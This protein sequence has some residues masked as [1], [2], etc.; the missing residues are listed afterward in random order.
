MVNELC[1]IY[2]GR[3]SEH[4]DSV[5]SFDNLYRVIRDNHLTL[6]YQL[7]HVIYIGLDNSVYL[8]A[9]DFENESIAYRVI[10][11]KVDLFDTL[12]ELHKRRCFLFSTL[13]SQNGEDGRMQGLAKILTIRSNLGEPLPSSLCL[14]KHHLNQFLKGMESDLRIPLTRRIGSRDDFESEIAAFN[15]C[16]MIVVKPNALGSSILTERVNLKDDVEIIWRIIEKILAHDSYAL[17]QEYIEGEEFTCG[18][19]EQQGSPSVLAIGKVNTKRNF[20]GFPEKND[21]ALNSKEIVL[22]P[23]PPVLQQLATNVLRLFRD[24][25]LTNIARFDVIVKNDI[26]YFLECNQFPSLHQYSFLMLM[27][28]EWK[29]SIADV[30]GIIIK[31]ED[32]RRAIDPVFRGYEEAST[33]TISG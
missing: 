31:N 13:F 26:I 12:K 10:E 5:E 7:T 8:H 1:I 15:E 16:E 27:L 22:Q 24:L 6:D 33:R 18:V 20:F 25:D 9:V 21:A 19:I 4:K 14:S 2:G 28:K 11:E 30:V 29:L 17:M 3:S 32:H 23:Y